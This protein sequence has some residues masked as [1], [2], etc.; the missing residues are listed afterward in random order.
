MT[1]MNLFRGSLILIATMFCSVGA[2]ALEI[3]ATMPSLPKMKNVDG[4][5]VGE[6]ELKGKTG[7]LVIF[8]CNHCPYVKAWEERLVQIGN[9]YS[10]KGIGVV[11]INSNDPAV[12][13]EDGFEKMQERAKQRNMKFPY[14]VDST[15]KVAS[16]FGATK[17]PEVYLFDGAGKLVYQGAIDDNSED[18]T[19]VKKTYLKDALNALIAKKPVTVASAKAI[20]CGIKFRKNKS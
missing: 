18:A 15:S 8:S 2:Q 4:K 19:A 7:T 6:K 17:T 3:G 16:S 20:G 14:V 13:P 1:H 12:Q 10:T 9:E 5:D 11:A